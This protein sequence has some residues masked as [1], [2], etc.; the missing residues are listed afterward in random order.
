MQVSVL[1]AGS[2]GITLAVL[3]HG[4]GHTVRLWEFNE[5]DARMLDTKRVHDIKLPGVRIPDDIMVTNDLSAVLSGSPYVVCA[6]P[7]QYMRNAMKS[8]AKLLRAPDAES[9]P[10]WIIVSKGIEHETG[11]T[12]TGVLQQE[13]PGDLEHTLA[14][15]SGPSH[16]EEVSRNMPT[17]VVVASWSPG[18]S[19]SIQNA[20]SNDTFRVYTNNDV[21]GVQV[22]ASIKNVIAI[23][24]GICDGL[25]FGDN[26][27]GALLTRGMLEMVRLG[28]R[29]GAKETTFTGLAGMGDLVTTCVSPH[30]RNRKI[31]ELI[32]SGLSLSEASEK[33]VMVAEGVETARAVHYLARK[34]EI[35]MPITS[36]VY[37]TLFED[38]P[39]Q[40]AV[41]DLMSR[42]VKPERWGV[43]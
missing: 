42:K 20:F 30:S 17:T 14:V 9:I 26:T 11:T 19:E 7:A 39:A 1:G 32:G 37:A 36:E 25:G 31:G 8:A 40:Q 12:L 2:W 10:G 27:R 6:V 34:Y 4:N 13:L 21:V 33:M 5:K 22:A 15:L 23:A 3:L 16:A 29:M 35:D 18:L 43:D 24:T 38:K 41:R 28:K